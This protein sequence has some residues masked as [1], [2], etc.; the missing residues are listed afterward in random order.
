PAANLRMPRFHYREGGT[1]ASELANFFAAKDGAEFPYQSIPQRDQAYLAEREKAHSKY[2]AGGWN[3]M[4]KGACIQ[5]HMV[6]KN[7]PAVAANNVNGPNLR[8]VNNRFRPEYLEQWIAKPTRILPYTAMPQNIP[9]AGPD[10][11]GSPPSLQGKT[12]QQVTALRDA[13]LNYSTAIEQSMVAEG[14]PATAAPA[15]APTA[16][17]AAG[18]E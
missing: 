11:P 13:L 16:K 17:P 18:G 5:C 12:A 8:Q 10:G 6:G 1:E 7:V 4:T 14:G 3:M 9:P 15:T 2:L